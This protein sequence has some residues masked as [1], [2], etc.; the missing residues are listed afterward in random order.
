M[1]NK[2]EDHLNFKLGTTYS[3]I[4]LLE[5]VHSDLERKESWILGTS[6][7]LKFSNGLEKMCIS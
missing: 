5:K 2:G 7:P 3:Y 6:D 1:L 4:C